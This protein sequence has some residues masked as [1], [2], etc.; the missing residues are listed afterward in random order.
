MFRVGSGRCSVRSPR[1]TRRV[2]P[3]R[4]RARPRRLQPRRQKP[5]QTPASP[6]ERTDSRSEGLRSS[7]E[8]AS[9]WT[10][11]VTSIPS[12]PRTRSTHARFPS[13]AVRA[14]TRTSMRRRRVCSST[15]AVR[16]RAKSCGCMSR[17]TST[18]AAV[19]F[20]CAMRMGAGAA[21]WRGRHGR[22]SWTTPTFP[23]PS[24][25]S[26]RWPFRRSGRRRLR[27]THKLSANAW[28]SVAVED[29]KS[30]IRHPREYPARPST[31]CRTWSGSFRFGG[32]RRARFRVALFVGK[33]R[34]R[35]TEG[36]PDDVTLW[37]G[38]LSG[39]VKTF[40]RDYSVRS[41]H[42]WRRRRPL[43]R[44]HHRRARRERRTCSR[45][46]STR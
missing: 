12:P 11:S 40:G 46:D 13:M 33:A 22:P 41:V 24:T 29:N 35:P 18:A 15:C 31:R 9:S 43:S 5:A 30:S 14:P 44:R 17:P 8:G 2:R 23:T 16:S 27:W 28:W 32:S 20:G 42:L 19:S 6:A 1:R 45:S 36:E 7:P 26:R 10:S 38:L 34:F 39:R 37:G 4:S 25:S 3:H 21:C